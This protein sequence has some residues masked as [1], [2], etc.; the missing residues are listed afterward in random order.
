MNR[1]DLDGA[2]TEASLHHRFAEVPAKAQI[3]SV[4][5]HLFAQ[6]LTALKAQEK[7]AAVNL[8]GT[9]DRLGR[10]VSG[11]TDCYGHLPPEEAAGLVDVIEGILE[12]MDRLGALPGGSLTPWNSSVTP[13][14]RKRRQ[15]TTD[16][17]LEATNDSRSPAPVSTVSPC[18]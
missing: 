18:G 1:G 15:A 17:T 16:L 7:G 5:T 4:M 10:T 3:C 9:A 11:A 14:R 6:C 13:T 2:L 8:Q 12:L